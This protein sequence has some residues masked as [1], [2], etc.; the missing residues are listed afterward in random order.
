MRKINVGRIYGLDLIV[1]PQFVYA[2][3]GLSAVIAVLG[4]VLLRLPVMQAIVGGLAFGLLHV[5]S[6]FL[7][8]FGHGIA[9][10][11]TGYPM[12]GIEFGR[13]G[14]LATTLYPPNEPSLAGPIHIRRALGGP[15]MS[16]GVALILGLLTFVLSRHSVMWWVALL[17]SWH[18]LLTFTL[19]MLIPVPWADGGTIAQWR[20][21]L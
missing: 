12:S 7:H 10:R 13:F 4:M 18:N 16:F 17:G 15:V 19:Q 5:L 8:D 21:H 6:V 11:S 1:Q 3:L 14:L 9:A 20:G 2:C